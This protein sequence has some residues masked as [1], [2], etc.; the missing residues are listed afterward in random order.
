MK[1]RDANALAGWTTTWHASRQYIDTGR[2]EFSIPYLRGYEY[3][4]FECV[5][6]WKFDRSA[7]RLGT[8]G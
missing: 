1:V 3:S 4:N 7:L 6:P 2:V 5:A 8:I